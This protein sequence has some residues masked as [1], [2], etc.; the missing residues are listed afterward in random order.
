MKTDGETHTCQERIES[1]DDENKTVKFSLFGGD[2]GEHYKTFLLT[3]QVTDDTGGGATA[4][5]KWTIEYERLH[6][7]KEPP[8]GWMEYVHK[9]TRDIDANLLKAD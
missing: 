8:H 4:T 3:L 7:E 6:D 9:C 1:T 5:V 2:I